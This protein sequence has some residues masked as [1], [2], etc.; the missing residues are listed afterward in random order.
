[1]LDLFK[2]NQ[3]DPINNSISINSLKK[4][5]DLLV[6]DFIVNYNNIINLEKP[7]DVITEESEKRKFLM[8]TRQTSV[9]KIRERIMS[10][11]GTN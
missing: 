7:E 9:S 3:E 11:L 10:L 1:V 8:Q 4:R 6:S 5:I 2:K